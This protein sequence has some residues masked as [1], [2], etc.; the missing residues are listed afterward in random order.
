M[1]NIVIIGFGNIGK[2]H[3]E[4]CIKNK[5]IQKIYIIDKN[6]SQFQNYKFENINKEIVI[7]NNIQ[8][9]E[10]NFFLAI[11]STD[12]MNR[13]SVTKNFLKKNVTKYI[14]FEK[15]LFNKNYHFNYMNK[16]LKQKKINAYVNCNRRLS[17]DYIN[18]KNKYGN[19][20]KKVLVEG[21]KWN[22]MSNSI[23]FIDLFMFLTNSSDIIL[24]DYLFEKEIS[25]NRNKYTEIH[26]KMSFI[27]NNKVLT[28]I[29]ISKPMTNKLT[30]YCKKI[31]IEIIESEK[32]INF[33]DLNKKIKKTVSL[34]EPI[35]VSNTTNLAIK[36]IY[37]YK[38]PK[39]IDFSSSSKHHKV[40]LKALNKMFKKTFLNNNYIIT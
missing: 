13:Y 5:N 6:K 37:K 19:Q 28:L 21:S 11:I 8:K 34:K 10:E 17:R 35:Y 31:I 20:I 27:S 38:K 26:A 30:I 3:F 4:A 7:V 22:F 2:R 39:L 15:F 16:L 29:D 33:L 25:S 36:N 18:I 14:L 32:I 1:A 23:H 24:N 9:L 40:F 12:S